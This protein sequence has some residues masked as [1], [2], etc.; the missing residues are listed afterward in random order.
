MS[1]DFTNCYLFI[2]LFILNEVPKI[3]AYITIPSP[4]KEGLKREAW[5]N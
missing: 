4:K 2:L 3:G 5:N 1:Q